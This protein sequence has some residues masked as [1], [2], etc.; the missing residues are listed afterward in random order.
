MTSESNNILDVEND[1]LN[2]D[3]I[4][5]YYFIDF[6]ADWCTPCKMLDTKLNELRQIY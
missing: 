5:D 3:N 2:F 6:Y 4:Y 1:N